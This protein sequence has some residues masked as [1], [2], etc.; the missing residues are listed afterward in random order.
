MAEAGWTEIQ[1]LKTLN[2]ALVRS[3]AQLADS[4][5]LWKFVTDTIS[6]SAE[7][8]RC[9]GAALLLLDEATEKV[10]LAFA[11]ENG[12]PL[13]LFQDVRLH[14]LQFTFAI[15]DSAVCREMFLR[16][17]PF[18]QDVS[19]DSE[20]SLQWLIPLYRR[21]ELKKVLGV[22]LKLHSRPIGLTCFGFAED[23]VPTEEQ[24]ELIETL[25]RETALAIQLLRTSSRAMNA[26]GLRQEVIAAAQV[27][28]QLAQCLATISLYLAAAESLAS[29]NPEI[30]SDA[31]RKAQELSQLGMK[32]ARQTSSALGPF[33][34]DLAD[35]ST[36]LRSVVLET[37]EEA[38]VN[39]KF[40]EHGTPS[41]STPLEVAK[42]LSAV[43]R[44]A[45]ENGVRHGKANRIVVSLSWYVGKLSVHIVD[46]GVGFDSTKIEQVNEGYG[47]SGMRDRARKMQGRLEV[48]S[49]PGV[50]TEIQFTV[51]IVNL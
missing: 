51:P 34:S 33:R 2:E 42:A 25:T 38:D 5:D 29:K 3:I 50:G 45:I 14:E 10:K 43:V 44:E 26:E 11:V 23:D 37:G 21:F 46:N 47:I 8:L 22:P 18:W 7:T 49:S 48:K 4:A 30:A 31:Q 35:V 13:D 24:V 16:K 15:E 19:E 20:V 40:L 32:L 9:S 12:F 41:T 1:R 28:E 6:F 17:K 27:H 36:L 39:I